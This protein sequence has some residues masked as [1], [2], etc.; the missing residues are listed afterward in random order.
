MQIAG[1][2]EGFA[3]GMSKDAPQDQS[4]GSVN[5]GGVGISSSFRWCMEVFYLR[6]MVVGASFA[7]GGWAI[8]LCG[9]HQGHLG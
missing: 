9:L 8:G 5:P 4:C 1:V 3:D 6:F 2:F 7:V